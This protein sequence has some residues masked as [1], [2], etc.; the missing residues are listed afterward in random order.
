MTVEVFKTNVRYKRQAKVLLDALSARFPRFRMNFDLEDCDKVLRIEGEEIPQQKI[1]AL[2]T[3]K[4]YQ[5]DVL[6]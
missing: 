6:E 5:C 2:V 4:G 1:T 3:E